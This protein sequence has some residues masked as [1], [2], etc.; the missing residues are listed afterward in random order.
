MVR[1]RLLLEGRALGSPSFG[2]RRDIFTEKIDQILSNVSL[3]KKDTTVSTLN[4]H[5]AWFLP[6]ARR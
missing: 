4:D 1:E 6:P 5:D 2:N 3:V